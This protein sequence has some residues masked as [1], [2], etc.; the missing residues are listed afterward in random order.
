GALSPPFVRH[1]NDGC[2]GHTWQSQDGCLD[3]GGI[4]VLSARDVHVLQ[5]VNNF[6]ETVVLSRNVSSPKPSVDKGPVG[7][8]RLVPISGADAGTVEPHFA[9][10]AG[11]DIL[12][13]GGNQADL[14]CRRR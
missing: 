1:S 12:A 4:Y 14:D 2:R 10:F 6:V 11:S 13:V 7:G 5:A 3:L 9:E 8:F